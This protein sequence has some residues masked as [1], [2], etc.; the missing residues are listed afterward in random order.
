MFATPPGGTVTIDL[1][2]SDDTHDLT[3]PG[4]DPVEI[5]AGGGDD[6]ITVGGGNNQIDHRRRR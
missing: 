2:G 4:D 5:T 6:Q 1:G 3:I